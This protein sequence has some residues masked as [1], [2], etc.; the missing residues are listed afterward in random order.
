[1][2]AAG[3]R[4]RSAAR[5]WVDVCIAL[6][7]A[8]IAA[9]MAFQFVSEKYAPD[10]SQPDGLAVGAA[11]AYLEDILYPCVR[12]FGFVPA[13]E[14][15]TNLPEW[16][17]F[18]SRTTD[19]FPCDALRNAPIVPSGY[20]S[21]LHRNL[22]RGLT[23]AFALA[24]PQ[25]VGFAYYQALQF[26]VLMVLLYGIFRLGMGRV[27][28]AIAMLPIALSPRHLEVVLQPIEYAKAPFFAACLL[29]V[30]CLVSRRLST[31]AAC[32]VALSTGL[33][34]G[35]GFGFKPD[36]FVCAPFALIAIAACFRPASGDRLRVRALVLAT[37]V[38]GVALSGYPFIAAHFFGP[39]RSLLPVQVLGGMAPGFAQ[40]Y[41]NAPIYDYGVIFDDFYVVAQINSYNQ[42]VHG[43]RAYGEFFSPELSLG[44]T[45]LVA[46]LQR[47]FV[48][49]VLLRTYA[50][51]LQILEA[52]PGGVAATAVG[53]LVLFFTDLRIGLFVV[54][55]LAY[56][57]GYV[58]LVFS[59]KHYFHLEFVPWWFVG[60]A[61]HHGCVWLASRLRRRTGSSSGEVQTRPPSPL[62]VTA[63]VAGLVA[64]AGGALVIA[65]SYQ[66]RQVR[67]L[68]AAYTR[69]DRIEL[70]DGRISQTATGTTLVVP[71]RVAVEDSV[72]D[73]QGDGG[74]EAGIGSTVVTDYLV[75]K[76]TCSGRAAAEVA[77]VYRSPKHWRHS[78]AV[79]C[80]HPS[81]GWTVMWPVYQ[82]QPDAIFEGFEYPNADV[83]LQSVGRVRNLADYP[84]LLRLDLPDDWTE[85]SLHHTLRADLLS[86][87]HVR[88]RPEAFPPPPPP[89]PPPSAFWRPAGE[90]PTPL[91]MRAPALTDWTALEGVTVS[92]ENDRQVVLGNHTAFG[93]QLMSPPIDVPSHD[94]LVV[95][96]YGAVDRG[97]VCVGIL[98]GSQQHWLVAPD[99]R[100][101]DFI[102]GTGLNT[103]VFLVFANCR[104]PADGSPAS[105]FTVQSVSYEFRNGIRN[106]LRALWPVGH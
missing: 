68:L 13:P 37:Y 85:R 56:M 53:L 22:H 1:V 59:P 61:V 98:D 105:R 11:G 106:R 44:A 70:L 89:L 77:A 84:L 75:L 38:A 73:V 12:R 104:Q 66:D 96:V 67:S 90:R 82:R 63:V 14:F 25:F 99:W 49:D 81:Q 30:G 26:S 36:V 94:T 78:M 93:Y 54:F 31:R 15:V 9:V 8:G 60:F 41:A 43:S 28:S 21:G 46:D 76:L 39:S 86:L 42:R 80:D 97:R 5:V 27:V 69:E 72:D 79:P 102:A 10:A 16:R 101:S 52:V 6:A 91:A 58:S 62:V 33:V 88:R 17:A 50:A 2:V 95:R 74:D 65:R 92:T 20:F 57:V 55:A 71:A 40:Q 34:I 3:G 87:T 4:P 64:A 83:R 45:R 100:R 7:V 19:R 29:G 32:A 51:V 23:T 48:G 24:G 103:R 35:F 47:T 18:I